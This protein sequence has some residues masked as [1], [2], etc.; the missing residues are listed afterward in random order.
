MNIKKF[1]IMVAVVSIF[2]FLGGM[3]G[4]WIFISPQAH[5]DGKSEKEFNV[6]KAKEIYIVNNANEKK[7]ALY[8]GAHDAPNLVFFDKNGVN[9]LNLGIAP[10]GNAGIEIIGSNGKKW[11]AP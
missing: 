3:F 8:L 10:A 2:S 9:K 7:V 11:L 6:I 5:A 4:Q 1:A